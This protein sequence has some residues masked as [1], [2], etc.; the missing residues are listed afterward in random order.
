MENLLLGLVGTG[1]LVFVAC[2]YLWSYRRWRRDTDVTVR[3]HGVPGTIIP[4]GYLVGLGWQDG[5]K[6]QWTTTRNATVGPDGFVDVKA[7]RT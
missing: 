7:K 2:C 6:V 3:C 5:P 1:L 4:K